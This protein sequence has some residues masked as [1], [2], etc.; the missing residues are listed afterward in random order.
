VGFFHFLL[1][2]LAFEVIP[3]L[4]INKLLF[5]FLGETS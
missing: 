4:L 3:L 5:S 1:Y 2:L